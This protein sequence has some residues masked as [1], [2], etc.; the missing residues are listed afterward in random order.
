MLRLERHD[1]AN[2]DDDGDKKSNGV[3][4]QQTKTTHLKT[5]STATGTMK[6]LSVVIDGMTAWLA[7]QS[8]LARE[9]E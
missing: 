5:S 7:S 8:G 3:C 4:D 6:M 1:G 9:R 2:T